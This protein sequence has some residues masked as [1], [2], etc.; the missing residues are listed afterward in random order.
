[1]SDTELP[2]ATRKMLNGSSAATAAAARK[3]QASSQTEFDFTDV[4]DQG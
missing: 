2:F 4:F 1:M 3:K